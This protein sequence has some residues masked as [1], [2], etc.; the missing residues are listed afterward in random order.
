MAHTDAG[1]VH[2]RSAIVAV[3]PAAVSCGAR[4]RALS[5]ASSHIVLTEPVPDVLEEFG[6]TGGEA[7]SDSR[8]FLHYFRTT[9]DGRIVFGWG[10]GRMAFGGRRHRDHRVDP[11]IVEHTAPTCAR[12]FPRCETARSPMPGAGRSTSRPLRLPIFRT[13]GRVHAGFGFTGNGVGPAELGGRILAALAL[14]VRDPETRLAMV[15]PE[16]VRFPPEPLR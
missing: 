8:T 14:D 11:A 12:S 7:I 2:A 3:N 5:V 10:G 15:E 1:V 16:A 4:P 6:W 9:Q 13:H